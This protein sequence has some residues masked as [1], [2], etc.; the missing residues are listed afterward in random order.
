MEYDACD[1]QRGGINNPKIYE[2]LGS[3]KIY[4]VAGKL[5][6]PACGNLHFWRRVTR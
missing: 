5:T 4:S 6:T 1:A 2:Y 3:G